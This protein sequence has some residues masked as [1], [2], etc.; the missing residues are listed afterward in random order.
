MRRYDSGEPCAG[1]LARMVRREVAGN[2]VRLCAG[3]LPYFVVL[4]QDLAVIQQ[5]QQVITAWLAPLGLELKAS[6]THI[7]HTLHHHEDRVGFDFLGCTIRQY[8]VGKT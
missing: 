4:H 8:P 3:Y 1:K 5:A 6:K 2:T 7:T